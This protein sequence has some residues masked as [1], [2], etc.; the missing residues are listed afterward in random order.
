MKISFCVTC[1]DKDA[2]LLQ[3]SLNRILQNQTTEPDEILV[4]AS[5]LKSL[6]C[7]DPKI[8]IYVFEKRMF[9]GGARNKGGELA[10][11]DVVCFCDIDDPIHPQKC[12]IIK[13]AFGNQDV[14]ALVHNYRLDTLDFSPIQD[15][16]D[17]E[18]EKVTS[19]DER[20]E[21]EQNYIFAPHEDI[22]R[23]NVKAQSGKPVCHGHLSAKKELLAKIKY[24]EDMWMG[25]DGDFCQSIVKSKKFDLYYTPL[26]LINYYNERI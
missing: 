11:G 8:K 17:I 12:E 15:T 2:H 1:Y 6:G 23:T 20:W 7:N 10:T 24:R 18:I 13:R 3:Q 4:I 16:Q 22:P 9:A 26:K 25:E 21:K 19:V 5:G 14:D